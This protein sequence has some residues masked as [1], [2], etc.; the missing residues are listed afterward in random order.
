MK[1]AVRIVVFFAAVHLVFAQHGGPPA[2]VG[3]VMSPISRSQSDYMQRTYKVNGI[4]QT[5]R[6]VPIRGTKVVLRATKM[7]AVIRELHSDDRGEFSTEM[8]ISQE[9]D[10]GFG[11]DVKAEKHG[12]KSAHAIVDFGTSG[13][14]WKLT[15]TL[16][17]LHEDANLLF[18]E[19]L[20]ATL[21]SRLKQL[22]L[23]DGLSAKSTKDYEH[24]VEEFLTN[25]N[26]VGAVSNFARVAGRDPSCAACRTMWG[27]AQLAMND[28]DGAERNFD[29][30]IKTIRGDASKARPEPDIAL[31][32][33]E[34]WRHEMERGAEFFYE[35]LK[36]AP[37]DPL[38]L[39]ELGR[40]QLA[41]EN[42]EEASDQLQQAVAAGAGPDAHLMYAEA[43]LH[44]DRP[45]DADRELTT[46]LA[47]R[48]VERMP[49]KIRQLGQEIQTQVRAEIALTGGIFRM[50]QSTNELIQTF[51]ALKGLEPAADQ[52]PL[53]PIL[54]ETGKRVADSFRDFPNTVSVEQVHQEKLQRRGRIEGS[55]DQEFRY[56]WLMEPDPSG[57]GITEYRSGKTG[58]V[59]T[60][61]GL[62]DGY[63]LTSGF[64]SAALYFHPFYHGDAHFR[65]LGRQKS[66]GR[67]YY[68]VAFAQYPGKAR[69]AGGFR[70]NGETKPTYFQGLAWIDAG[71][72]EIV[73]LR[74]D[75]L[76]PLPEVRLERQSTEIDFGAVRFK[77]IAAEFWLPQRVSVA[78]D[79]N[80]KRLR[81]EHRYSKFEL[82]NVSA[83][84]DEN[85]RRTPTTPASKVETAPGT[86]N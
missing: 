41:Q 70:V 83:T 5:V 24:G 33:M 54:D 6:R 28:W 74:Q 61:K 64:T 53:A 51:P 38:A 35:A 49:Q 63:M 46:Y 80:G 34:T 7:A 72:Y 56:L 47:G 19:D 57:P 60:L 16:P 67:E 86:P 62:D 20:I 30:A 25:D 13:S 55:Q 81:N 26:P 77:Q 37:H 36:F 40:T 76:S 43:L 50:D 1:T 2:G 45:K 69:I 65:Y 21:S 75:L 68:V 59:A 73:R 44:V 27:L 23:A 22:S 4:V 17:E 58:G 29:E 39:Q 42:W 18:Q 71:S 9:S 85:Q 82:F 14:T 12:Y 3:G 31:G 8:T 11:V 15:I 79:W 52:S 66:E 78:V 32:V 10:V 84:E 48:D